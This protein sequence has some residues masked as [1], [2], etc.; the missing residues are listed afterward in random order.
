MK[1]SV[2]ATFAMSILVSLGAGCGGGGSGDLVAKMTGFKNQMCACK[3]D[4]DPTGCATK[5]NVARKQWIESVDE[6]SVK[7]DLEEKLEKIDDEL[8]ACRDE[9][10]K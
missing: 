2:F 9:I 7:G 6:K 4:K 5:V 8:K 3:N 10:L 1:R